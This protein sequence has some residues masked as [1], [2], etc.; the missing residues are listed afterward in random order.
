ML[1]IVSGGH[2][3]LPHHHFLVNE[4]G[5]NLPFDYACQNLST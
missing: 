2:L 1:A 5:S 3:L 4:D